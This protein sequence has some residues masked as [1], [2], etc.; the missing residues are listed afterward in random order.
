MKTQGHPRGRRGRV[1]GPWLVLLGALALI[2]L[3]RALSGDVGARGTTRV[4]TLRFRL[5]GGEGQLLPAWEP[6][7]ARA[8]ALADEVDVRDRAAV[9]DLAATVAA[10]PFVAEVGLAEVLWPDGISLPLRLHSPVACLRQ[11]DDYLLV[12]ETGTLLP[13]AFFA[14]PAVGAGYLPVLGPS[15]LGPPPE[16]GAPLTDPRLRAAFETALSL[17][18]HLSP[19][20]LASLGACVID[21]TFLADPAGEHGGLRLELEERRVVLWGRPPASGEPGELPVAIKWKH[22]EKGLEHLDK[23]ADWS[24]W[25]VRWDVPEWV[26]R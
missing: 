2:V 14:P 13:G 20:D 12:S 5:E 9:D 7:L 15:L 19:E 18:Q 17:W 8:L 1:A 11:G 16:V 6:F 24:L 23:G 21:G 10:L 4:D 3:L 25:D 22:L 26:P